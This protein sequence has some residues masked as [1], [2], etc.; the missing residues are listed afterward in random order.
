MATITGR[1][2][3]SA[4]TCRFPGRG[5]H[6]DNVC[7]AHPVCTRAIAGFLSS[8]SWQSRTGS[9]ER[10]K[11]QSHREVALNGEIAWMFVENRS[12]REPHRCQLS[13]HRGS[14]SNRRKVSRLGNRQ[15]PGY[16]ARNNAVLLRGRSQMM[17]G[18]GNCAESN[19]WP[20]NTH[21]HG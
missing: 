9:I 20:S 1:L 21:S 10:N 5:S 2:Q 15:F 8:W 16:L 14:N 6:S 7:A 18:S 3:C 4:D 17:M 19:A 12:S 13:S 11:W